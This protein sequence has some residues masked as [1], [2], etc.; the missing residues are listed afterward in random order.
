MIKYRKELDNESIGK[1][2]VKG[3]AMTVKETLKTWNYGDTDN[4]AIPTLTIGGD[5][6]ISGARWTV[7]GKAAKKTTIKAIQLW[8]DC[9]DEVY[10]SLDVP[11]FENFLFYNKCRNASG[12]IDSSHLTWTV[13]K[14]TDKNKK[15][16]VKP[17]NYDKT[18]IKGF[19]IRMGI[20]PHKCFE[21]PADV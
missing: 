1:L 10:I 17:E 11:D 5:G 15:V 4:I 7:I 13:M 9:E 20:R 6:R 16:M 2:I 21:A 18:G 14:K 19:S 3:G 8:P 12:W